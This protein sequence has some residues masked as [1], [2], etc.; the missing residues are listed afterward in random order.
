MG[1]PTSRTV[2]T[3]NP[4]FGPIPQGYDDRKRGSRV[5]GI[6]SRSGC[7]AAVGDTTARAHTVGL[8]RTSAERFGC[9]RHR[10]AVCPTLPTRLVPR[11]GSHRRRI[12]WSPRL[13]LPLPGVRSPDGRHRP[14][15]HTWEERVVVPSPLE[16]RCAIPFYEFGNRD[17]RPTLVIAA[18][19]GSDRWE[20][21]RVTTVRAH[22][23]D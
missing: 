12:R 15:D 20:T 13:P 7:R 4:Y 5:R 11:C 1:R 2:I 6:H 8:W 23:H 14:G 10:T 9:R 3:T 17:S 19:E 21:V 22:S 18:T 16:T